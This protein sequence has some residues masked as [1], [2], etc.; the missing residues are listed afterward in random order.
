M[1]RLLMPGMAPPRGRA[2]RRRGWPSSP[3]SPS[4]IK[5]A[6]SSWRGHTRVVLCDPR[7]LQRVS[8]PCS[9]TSTARRVPLKPALPPGKPSPWWTASAH[10]LVEV[11]EVLHG[12][13]LLAPALA[14][15]RL[16]HL[17]L[18]LCGVRVPRAS[19]QHSSIWAS[20]LGLTGALPT[21]RGHML[22]LALP[23]TLATP[24]HGTTGQR[25][26]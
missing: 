13:G 12:R 23:R 1:A 19:Q 18:Q 20:V 7:K 5:S 2:L 16:L 15:A 6:I 9:R 8:S 22:R 14:L 10:L 21:S 4:T 17:V 26:S 25:R 3:S 11:I 24:G